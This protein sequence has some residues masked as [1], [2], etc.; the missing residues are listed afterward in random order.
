MGNQKDNRS[1]FG[2]QIRKRHLAKR[3]WTCLKTLLKSCSSAFIPH[4]ARRADRN[5]VKMC[6]VGGRPKWWFSDCFP[7]KPMKR[8]QGESSKPIRVSE[9]LEGTVSLYSKLLPLILFHG[10]L[11]QWDTRFLIVT[12]GVWL[13]RASYNT[14]HTA[15]ATRRA[16]RN[17]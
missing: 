2:G 9:G 16:R 8:C 15:A 6:Q 7:F 1:H 17:R 3:R 5:D 10:F 14:T 13:K 11:V 4:Q 12:Q